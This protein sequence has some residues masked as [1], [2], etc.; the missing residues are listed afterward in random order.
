VTASTTV[1]PEAL[2]DVAARLRAALAE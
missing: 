2:A 1:L